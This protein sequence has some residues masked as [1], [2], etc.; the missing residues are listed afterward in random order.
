MKKFLLA[1]VAT[2]ALSSF[3]ATAQA[4]PYRAYRYGYAPYG[5]GVGY[6]GYYGPVYRPYRAYRY[7]YGY[8][9]GYGYAYGGPT[10]DIIT[11]ATDRSFTD[12]ATAIVS[13]AGRGADD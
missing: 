3:A 9:Y 13:G 2:M 7:G 4:Y 8:P 11:R 1:L 10:P 6:R 5:Y 12:H